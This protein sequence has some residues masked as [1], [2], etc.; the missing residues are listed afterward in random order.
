VQALGGLREGHRCGG[1]PAA[2]RPREW[3]Q[4]RNA[5]SIDRSSTS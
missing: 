1:E 2:E 5:G 3:V 4:G